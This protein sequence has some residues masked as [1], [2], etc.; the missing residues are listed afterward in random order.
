MAHKAT[1][2][3]ILICLGKGGD[4]IEDDAFIFSILHVSFFVPA[5]SVLAVLPIMTTEFLFAKMKEI[6]LR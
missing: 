2:V 4:S 6:L 5:M 3:W 1:A